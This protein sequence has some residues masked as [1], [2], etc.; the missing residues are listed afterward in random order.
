MYLPQTQFTDSNLTFVVRASGDPTALAAAARA[1]I[2]EGVPGAPIERITTL[3]ELVARS[4]G[5]RRF[6]MILLTLFGVVALSLTAVGVY[7]VIA[8]SVAERT[9]EIGIRGALGASRLAVVRLVVGGGFAAIVVGVV[10]GLGGAFAAVRL[11]Q[12][13]LYDVSPHDMTSLTAAVGVI[14]ITALAAHAVPL[15]RALRVQPTVA[16][17]EE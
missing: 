12:G 8:C 5:P 14:V 16:L 7:G 4:I 2:R 6:I 3:D 9:R 17:R 15:A 10:V 11:L 1:A 13:S